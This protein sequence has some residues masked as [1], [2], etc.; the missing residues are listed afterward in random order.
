[1][2]SSGGPPPPDQGPWP[3]DAR[4]AGLRETDPAGPCASQRPHG[5]PPL[6]APVSYSTL[7]GAPQPVFQGVVPSAVSCSPPKP[8][9]QPAI[10]QGAPM[11]PVPLQ[12][13]PNEGAPVPPW[14]LLPQRHPAQPQQQQQQPQQQQQQQ[15]QQ[16][17]YYE[18]QQVVQQ[19][20]HP[21]R[22][23]VMQQGG[24]GPHSGEGPP[25]PVNMGE[26]PPWQP[27]M[28]CSAE[29]S[30]SFACASPCILSTQAAPP[31]AVSPLP[32]GP[33]VGDLPHISTQQ[34]H[35]QQW[36]PELLL[37]LLPVLLSRHSPSRHP[38]QP[39]QQQQQPQQQ[40]QQQQQH[41]YYEG[42]QVVQQPL[43]PQ[44][45]PVMQQG[46]GGPHSGEGPPAPVNMGE[47]PPWQPPMD[48]S[49][50][51]SV[52]FACTSPC[53]IST[54]APPP[55]A[56][57][58]LPAGPFVGD[59]P[60]IST[61]QP[62]LQQWQPA[63]PAAAQNEAL[64]PPPG[65]AAAAAAAAAPPPGA[66]VAPFP[67]GGVYPPLG[68]GGQALSKA[69]NKSSRPPKGGGACR[70][71]TEAAGEGGAP[72]APPSG[73]RPAKFFKQHSPGKGA[74]KPRG[75]GSGAQ[76]VA[77]EDGAPKDPSAGSVGCQGAPHGG[78]P[79]HGAPMRPPSMGGHCKPPATGFDKG[80]GNSGAPKPNP[81]PRA[82][83]P[84]EVMAK[85]Y[86]HPIRIRESPA[87]VRVGPQVCTP[88][89]LWCMQRAAE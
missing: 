73:T 6:P 4:M 44:R 86:F 59:L 1:M 9:E 39:Q 27:P 31:Y 32:A 22:A 67:F 68:L 2:D 78:P 12:P 37:L 49:A 33:F 10:G 36:Q 89:F 85:M 88:L 82:V 5:G 51:R 69:E 74:P 72:P 57:S 66:A 70:R 29:R 55:Y 30:V 7:G 75:K 41:L 24:G 56:V 8:L 13:E 28:D 40:Q 21:Q 79:S 80:E 61:Q 47:L 19:Q 46:G 14:L 48:C 81:R 62:H 17:L 42:Q 43:H 54:Q 87:H 20:L 11:G 15:Q 23:P 50:E 63:A 38:A 64:Q 76:G 26:L 45:A 34:P 52:S 84:S 16:H 25:A 77:Q 35:L 71:K 65:P 18:G 53:I 83:R 3:G 60:H 58:P